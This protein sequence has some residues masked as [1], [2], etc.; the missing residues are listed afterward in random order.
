MTRSGDSDIEIKLGE[1]HGA[2]GRIEAVNLAFEDHG[3]FGLNI[4][5]DFG[6]SRQETGF[7]GLGAPPYPQAGAFLAE[8]VERIGDLCNARGRDV[9]VLRREPYSEIIGL[10]PLRDGEPLIFAE[11][12]G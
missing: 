7:I 11:V 1:L 3:I 9:I 6:G 12:F 8:V 4:S 2:I 10:M 5:F